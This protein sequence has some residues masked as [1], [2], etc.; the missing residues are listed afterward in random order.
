MKNTTDS[1][2]ANCN[3]IELKHKTLKEAMELLA[4]HKDP[5]FEW[6]KAKGYDPDNGGRL[7]IDYD[8][9]N[10]FGWFAL[11][12]YVIV[13]KGLVMNNKGNPFLI[14]TSEHLFDVK[15]FKPIFQ[16]GLCNDRQKKK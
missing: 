10:S 4:N 7:I 11:P 14:N 13:N 1:T 5:L 2:T 8:M 6:M 15:N 12:N 3:P 16:K 9:A